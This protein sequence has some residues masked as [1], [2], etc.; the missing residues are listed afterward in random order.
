MSQVTAVLGPFG[1]R[2]ASNHE[3][4]RQREDRAAGACIVVFSVMTC[5]RAVS[6]RERK[7]SPRILTEAELAR[8]F[9]GGVQLAVEN[10]SVAESVEM[11]FVV[12]KIDQT[13]AGCMITRTRA[14]NARESGGVRWEP[15]NCC[16]T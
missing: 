6:V 5:V 2:K 3:H 15:S 4:S 8:V 13:R 1:E 9:R 7:G 16:W 10:R 12:A 11:R 14:A